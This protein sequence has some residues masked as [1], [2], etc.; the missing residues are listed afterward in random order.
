MQQP[1]TLTG[2]AAVFAGIVPA[3]VLLISSALA[4]EVP[5]ADEAPQVL[6]EEEPPAHKSK[7]FARFFDDTDGKLDFSKTL[8]KGG[9]LPMPVIITEPA[10]DGGFGIV[11]QFITISKDD[12]KRVTR[13]M[14]GAIKTGNGSYGY[15]YFQSGS[16]AGGRISYKFGVGRG[17]ITLD[18]NTPLLPSGLQYTNHYEY[19]VLGSVRYHLGDRRFSIGPSMDFRKLRSQIDFENPPPE[20]LPDF[21]HTLHTGAL[22]G[23]LHFDSRDN[24]LTPTAGVNAYVDGKFNSGAFGSDRNFQVYDIDA[25]LFRKLSPKWRLGVKI[26]GA[27][28]RG[29]YPSF[30]APAIDLRGVEAQHYQGNSVLSTEL[31]VTHQLSSRWSLLAFAGYGTTDAGDRRVFQDSGAIFAGGVGFRYRIARAVGL[32]AGIDLAV[33]PGG[34]TFYLQFGHAWSFGMD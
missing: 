3:S 17:K 7:F 18:I 5:A 19:G 26:A 10:V 30:F 14:A 12:P 13:R 21:N 15:G 24:P 1:A 8:A 11:A 2:T 16:A 28:A 23:G 31:E 4:Q 32:D 27:G 25:Y 22:G 6:P 34:T 20:F 9:F 33:G 29:D